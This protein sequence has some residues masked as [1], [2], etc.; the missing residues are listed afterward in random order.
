MILSIESSCDDSSLALTSIDDATLIYHIKLSQDE[1]HSTYGGIVPEIASRLHAQ[2]LP[3]ILKKLKV[4]LN[5]DL[6]AIKAIAVTTRPGL[7]VTLIEGLMMAKALC[8][9]LQVPLICVNH[10][11]GH[12]YSLCIRNA[13]SDS[14][15]TLSKPL[16]LPQPL[17][18][19][20]VSGGHTQILQMHNFNTISL[21]AQ[22]LDDSFG[23]SFDKVAKYLGLGYPGGPLIESYAKEF[24]QNYPHITSHS[25]PVPLLHNQK[26]QFSFSGLKNAVRLAIEALSQ[27]LSPKD[28]GSICAGFQQSACE[29]IVRK[30]R[31][32]FQ[33]PQTQDLA[34][35][36]IVGGASANTYLRTALS[37]LCAE[38]K[39][40]LHL[41]ELAFC[42]D[43]AA[44]IGA[45]AI[46]HYK[47]QDFTPI[48]EAQISPKSLPSDFL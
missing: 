8:L 7:S 41:A 47:R 24:I 30:V 38:Y 22:S 43:N 28:L 19:L 20:L 14:Q 4:F 48:D 21:V 40:Q 11:K 44:M 3:E 46:E 6:S 9:G 26:L 31:L 32:Y 2:R 29:H 25:F 36:A 17:G 13:T 15:S 10:L 34:D 5:N 12:I 42:A 23:E 35:F 1:E 45:V 39:K 37:E 27:P 18:I 16:S 33:N